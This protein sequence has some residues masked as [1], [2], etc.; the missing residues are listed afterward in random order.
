MLEA[1][2]LPNHLH[3]QCDFFFCACRIFYLVKGWSGWQNFN[4]CASSSE[5][6]KAPS[7][8]ALLPYPFFSK[9]FG[10]MYALP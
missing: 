5:Y 8:C 10:W 9:L 2:N 1:H 7:C 4:W 3:E 6:G